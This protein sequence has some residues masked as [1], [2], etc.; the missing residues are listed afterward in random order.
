MTPRLLRYGDNKKFHPPIE[1]S[2]SACLN[3]R[4]LVLETYGNDYTELMPAPANGAAMPL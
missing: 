2:S 3:L 4:K 1:F